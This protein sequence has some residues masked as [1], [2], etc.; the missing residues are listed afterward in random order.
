MLTSL[1][2]L[3]FFYSS[4]VDKYHIGT[5]S[6][7][8]CRNTSFLKCSKKVSRVI[9]RTLRLKLV[10]LRCEMTAGSINVLDSKRLSTQFSFHRSQY[11][12]VSG[13]T[14]M[15]YNN[16]YAVHYQS[17]WPAG[18]LHYTLRKRKRAIPNVYNLNVFV[19]SACFLCSRAAHVALQYKR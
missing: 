7:R 2:I 13:R 11:M 12:P 6:C 3:A 18:A 15:V 10:L 9:G 1:S 4:P 17:W 8:K 5:C 14:L 16:V 19:L